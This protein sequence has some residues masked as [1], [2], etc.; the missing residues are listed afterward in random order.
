MPDISP[1]IVKND[2]QLIR[3]LINPDHIENGE[4]LP[5]AIS[6]TDLRKRGFSVHRLAY[7]SSEIVQRSIDQI[8]SKPFEG[9]RRESQG[10]AVLQTRDV[11]DLK[12][13][14]RQAFVVIDTAL[15]CNAGHASI[16]VSYVS[17]TS[18]TDSRVR[19]LRALLLPL[20]QERMSVCEAFDSYNL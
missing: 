12:D 1:G 14:D 2:E 10:V 5:R 16:Y 17:D 13:D 6:L 7:V 3:A 19:K 11:R 20:L 8:L 9:R 15:P 4:L 18:L